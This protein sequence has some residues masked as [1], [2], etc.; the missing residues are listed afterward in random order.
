MWFIHVFR[1]FLVPNQLPTTC[2]CSIFRG[3]LLW[4]QVHENS[5]TLDIQAKQGILYLNIAR[6]F[7]HKPNQKPL[8]KNRA[9]VERDRLV[10]TIKNKFLIS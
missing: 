10:I 1:Y 6:L 7:I 9:K 3:S 5:L 2:I 8:R 4:N